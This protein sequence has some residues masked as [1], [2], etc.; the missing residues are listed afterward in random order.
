[1]TIIFL[2]FRLPDRRRCAD[3]PHVNALEEFG[4]WLM[5]VTTVCNVVFIVALPRVV[6][7]M[8]GGGGMDEWFAGDPPRRL[9]VYLGIPI[10]SLVLTKVGIMLGDAAICGPSLS[11]PI[12]CCC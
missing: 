12:E 3:Y 9:Q 2:D 4:S 10:V 8:K 11:I 7:S 1:M 6:K 5:V